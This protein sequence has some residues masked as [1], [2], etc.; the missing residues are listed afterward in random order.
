LPSEL[1]IILPPFITNTL[2]QRKRINRALNQV[3][4][5]GQRSLVLLNCHTILQESQ[6]S[7]FKNLGNGPQKKKNE[8]NTQSSKWLI[9]LVN[10]LSYKTV[11]VNDHQQAKTEHTQ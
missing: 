8:Q 2:I 9:P 11:S 10:G 6:R 7:T 1:F 3:R 5:F 4:H